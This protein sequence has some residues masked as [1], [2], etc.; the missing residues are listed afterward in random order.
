V[1]SLRAVVSISAAVSFARTPLHEISGRAQ[2]IAAL[3]W[4]EDSR[5]DPWVVS[6]VKDFPENQAGDAEAELR[7]V[8]GGYWVDVD[9]IRDLLDSP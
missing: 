1:G 4:R 5:G 3:G 9:A 8:M 6:F 2:K 7:A